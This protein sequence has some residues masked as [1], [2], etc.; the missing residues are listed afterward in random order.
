[1]N[2]SQR[3]GENLFDGGKSRH[4]LVTRYIWVVGMEKTI[5]G[6]FRRYQNLLTFPF[7]GIVLKSIWIFVVVVVFIKKPQL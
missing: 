5:A 1:M 7:L 4:S 3:F 6:T 2:F